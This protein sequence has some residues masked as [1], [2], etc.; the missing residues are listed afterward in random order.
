MVSVR[1]FQDP[2]EKFHLRCGYS[3]FGLGFQ[4]PAF[5]SVCQHQAFM[6][7][8][9]FVVLMLLLLHIFLSFAIVDVARFIHVR[10]SSVESPSEEMIDP[11]YLNDFTSSRHS[12]FINIVLLGTVLLLTIILLFS[13]LI[14]IL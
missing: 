7:S 14:Y 1:N 11:R 8:Y 13:A 4:G 5:I 2:S 9:F 3:S 6:E 12:P 10:I